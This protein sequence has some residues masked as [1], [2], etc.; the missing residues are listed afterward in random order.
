MVFDNAVMHHGNVIRYMRMSVRFRRF[1][2]CCPAGVSNPG[3]A[4]QRMLIQCISQH[5]DFTQTT[6][7]PHFPVSID[8]SQTGRVIPAVFE[9]A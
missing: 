8:D 3:A 1:A 6:Q 9:T 2:V 7:A 4:M 5:L